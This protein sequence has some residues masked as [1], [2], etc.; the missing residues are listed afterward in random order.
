MSRWL[1][2]VMAGAGFG[3]TVLL[4]TWAETV[5]AAWYRIDPDDAVLTRFMH[6]LVAALRPRV[7]TLAASSA[8]SSAQPRAPR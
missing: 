8:R 4:A 7:A 2:A 6:G 1:T 5:R 3:K